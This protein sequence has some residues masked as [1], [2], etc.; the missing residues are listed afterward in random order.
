M[1][2]TDSSDLQ[3]VAV[4]DEAES[5][6]I[7]NLSEAVGSAA[8][9]QQLPAT[10]ASDAGEQEIQSVGT[11]QTLPEDPPQDGLAKAE[12]AVLPALAPTAAEVKCERPT[13]IIPHHSERPTMI[14][15]HHSGLHIPVV[16]VEP[17]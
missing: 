2:L 1:L 5:I 10:H 13:L 14:I 4:L 9:L 15:P 16:R 8:Q 17:R 12:H 11:M 3:T 7:C 6:Q